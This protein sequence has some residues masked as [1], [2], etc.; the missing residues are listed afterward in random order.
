MSAQPKLLILPL[1]V[2]SPALCRII[3]SH[4]LSL[5]PSLSLSL[6][7]FSSS[8]FSSL[9]PSSSYSA[10]SFCY[11]FSSSSWLSFQRLEGG[12][13]DWRVALNHQPT[14]LAPPPT[15]SATFVSSGRDHHRQSSL[16]SP[17]RSLSFSSILT[18]LLDIL[19]GLWPSLPCFTPTTSSRSPKKSSLLAFDD[20]APRLDVC[21]AHYTLLIYA[22][23]H[24]LHSLRRWPAAARYCYDFSPI[25]YFPAII[26][27]LDTSPNGMLFFTR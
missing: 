17:S 7:L 10:L 18:F 11:I 9:L 3:S 27:S 23:I 6:P 25:V 24:R 19:A 22:T 20:L 12:H 14:L 16:L 21:C 4:L 1:C 2:V 15:I 13:P 26:M 8:R 5:S